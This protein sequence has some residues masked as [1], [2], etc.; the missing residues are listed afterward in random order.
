MRRKISVLLALCLLIAVFSGCGKADISAYADE[1]ILVTGL[2][3]EDFYITAADLAQM[4]CVS[5]TADGK[6]S[7]GKIQAYGPTLDTFLAEYGQDIS[8][9]KAIRFCA[10]DD[11]DIT[12]G[13]ASW[14][15]YEV[16]FSIA[17]GSEPLEDY[18]KPMRVVMPGG[19]S[20]SC[21][22]LVDEINFVRAGE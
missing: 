5:A 11:Y 2:L 4:K 3:E 10:S 19:K 15:K 6:A 14:E 22:R 13:R 8:D 12:I 16:I 18:Q 1:K 7:Q 9:F 20:S 17:N 21:I